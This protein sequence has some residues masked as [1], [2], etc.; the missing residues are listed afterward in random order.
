MDIWNLTR[1][2]DRLEELD[3]AIDREAMSLARWIWEEI[4]L[5]EKGAEK[6]LIPEDLNKLTHVIDRL[7]H[8]EPVQYITGHSW[9]YGQKFKVNN[10]VLIPRPETEELVEWIIG[11][12]KNNTGRTLRI[13]DIGTGSGCI[14]I[15]LKNYFGA[16]AEVMAMDISGRALQVAK[17]NA[18]NLGA[19]VHFLQQ[20]FLERGFEGLGVFDIIVSNPP[21]ISR[22]L[23]GDS[24]LSGLKYEPGLALYPVGHDPDVFYKKIS[25]EA[26]DYLEAGGACYLELNEFRAET[27]EHYFLIDQ[28]NGVEVRIDMQGLPRMIRAVKPVFKEQA[29]KC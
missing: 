25:R 5:F 6:E 19:D 23:S 21:Y 4:L 12:F 1:V 13:L 29:A 18:L 16:R 7:L 15:V 24:I 2:A 9:F 10:D 26:G 3:I 11:D 28:W 22:A 17:F 14:A 20:D 27:I 8:G